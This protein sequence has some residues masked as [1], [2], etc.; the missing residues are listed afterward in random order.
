MTTLHRS[1]PVSRYLRAADMVEDFVP[2]SI[3]ELVEVAVAHTVRSAIFPV[4]G[5]ACGHEK[6]NGAGGQCPDC[7]WS[8][9]VYDRPNPYTTIEPNVT[10]EAG[11]A[12]HRAIMVDRGAGD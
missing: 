12:V 10:S 8:I 11:R 3:D 4:N 2:T 5:Y 1:Q 7:G 9:Q 6:L